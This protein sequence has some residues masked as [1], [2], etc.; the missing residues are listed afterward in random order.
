MTDPQMRRRE[1]G[2]I[3]AWVAT[4]DPR[5]LFAYAVQGFRQ[6]CRGESVVA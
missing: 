4:G 6:K 2:A 1:V 5:R 3:P